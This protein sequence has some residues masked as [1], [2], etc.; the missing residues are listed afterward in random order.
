MFLSPTD[1]PVV[2]GEGGPSVLHCVVSGRLS[3]CSLIVKSGIDGSESAL[4]TKGYE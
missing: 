2:Y 4:K 1:V 3:E